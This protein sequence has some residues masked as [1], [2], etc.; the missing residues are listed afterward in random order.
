M[1]EFEVLD[2]TM[3]I[4]SLNTPMFPGYPQPLKATF[5]T[6]KKHGYNSNVWFFIEHTS[7]HVDAPKHFVEGG[8]PIN[9]MPVNTYIGWSTVLDFSQVEP[10]HTITKEELKN[11]LN[12]LPFKVD[13]EWILLIYTG[14]SDKAGTSEWFDHPGLSKEACEYLINIGIKG[15]GLD[16]PSPDHEPFPAHNILLPEG[17]AIFENLVNLEGLIGKKFI[18]VGLPLKLV[19]G[20]ASPIRAIALVL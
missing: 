15:I 16:A 14:Y 10:N 19:D 5:T 18:F 8:N 11:K 6:I 2:L 20:T 13:K 3:P 17:K 9:E 7:T 4:K 1:E 12:E